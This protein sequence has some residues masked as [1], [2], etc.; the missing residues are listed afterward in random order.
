MESDCCGASCEIY[1][2]ICPSCFEPCDWVEIETE[3]EIKLR[4]PQKLG[5]E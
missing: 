5:H 2:Y 3:E 4:D 1:E